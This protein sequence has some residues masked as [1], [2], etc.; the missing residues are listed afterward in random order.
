MR[1][2]RWLGLLQLLCLCRPAEPWYKPAAGPR[3]YSVGRASGLLSGL[4]HSPHTRRSDTDGTAE[5]GT[6]ALPP[7]S[8]RPPARLR[9]AALCVTDVAPEPRSCRALPGAPGALQ[10]KADVTMSWDPLEC[11]TA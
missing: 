3:H 1:A 2:A 10:C 5:A 7:G 9:A 4:R 11:A 6:G 8:A